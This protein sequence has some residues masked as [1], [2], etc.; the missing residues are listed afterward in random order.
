MKSIYYS[1]LSI[2]LINILLFG[3]T[4]SSAINDFFGIEMPPSEENYFKIVGYTETS[5]ISYQSTPHM[6]PNLY[7][8]AGLEIENV[9]VII[10]NGTNEPVELN[11]NEDQFLLIEK[12]G[13]EY[14]LDKGSMLEYD[15][16][17]PIPSNGSVELV[18]E[19]PK[20]YVNSLYID[21]NADF[22]NDMAREQNTVFYDKERI[23]KLQIKLGYTR[24]LI[25]KPVTEITK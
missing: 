19:L 20:D 24:T 8:W 22:V 25:L 17:T 1:T 11:Y 6:N 12:E 5:G 23:A 2:I 9:R 15:N 3:C 21:R 10:T 4:S 18:F 16:K 14:I 7:A 13:D